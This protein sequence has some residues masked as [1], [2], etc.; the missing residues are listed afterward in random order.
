MGKLKNFFTP[1]HQ[2]TKRDY[3]PRMTDKKVECM[4]IAKKY[5]SDYWDGNRRFGY[6]GYRYIPDR[7]KSVA[8]ELIKTYG[9]DKGSKVLDVGCG[10]GFLLHE[11]LLIEPDLNIRGFDISEH[12]INSA[13]DLVREKL[14]VHKAEE[15]FPFSNKEFDLV[16]SLGTLHNLKIF[17]LEKSIKE[18]E[19]VGRQG[20][21]MSE[22]YR[23]DQELFNL[24]CWALTCESF[25]NKEEWI[26]L[27]QHFGY[28]GDY[29]F[30][31]FE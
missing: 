16:I 2:L 14:F 15:K 3:L 11:M 17:D 30:I 27:Y 29:E 5:E 21:I 6:G 18:I 9:L 12:A 8:E 24:Q 28:K 19:R 26:W 7:W 4:T 23:N 25:F 10:K 13:T 1:L 22:S 31:Y 20:Y